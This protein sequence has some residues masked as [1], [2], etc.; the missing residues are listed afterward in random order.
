MKRIKRIKSVGLIAMSALGLLASLGV[1]SAAAF[2]P[3]GTEVSGVDDGR[4]I[5]FGG[6]TTCR[7]SMSGRVTGLET[8]GGGTISFDRV[9]FAGCSAGATVSA[10]ALPWTLGTSSTLTA[11]LF[12]VDVSITTSRGTCRYSG[13]LLGYTNGAGTWFLNGDVYQRVAGCG[14]ARQL[15]ARLTEH[16]RDADGNPVGL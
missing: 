6:L 9:S 11:G 13:G 5:D 3:V 2:P 1:Q 4:G 8:F 10:N 15:T 16:V 12:G 14:G 7:V